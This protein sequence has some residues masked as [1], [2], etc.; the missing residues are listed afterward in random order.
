MDFQINRK[1][2]N[3]SAF[4]VYRQMMQGKGRWPVA[5]RCLLCSFGSAVDAN[6]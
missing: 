5:W 3:L 6:I 1:S 2:L 4:A